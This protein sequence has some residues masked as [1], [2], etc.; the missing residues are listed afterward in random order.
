MVSLFDKRLGPALDL[1]ILFDDC[2]EFDARS[3][4]VDMRLEM[5]WNM[6]SM[7]LH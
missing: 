3:N 4:V 1:D 5:L 2:S 6:I 7:N